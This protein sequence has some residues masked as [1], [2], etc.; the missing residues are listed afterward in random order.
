MGVVSEATKRMLVRTS[1]HRL[2]HGEGREAV[3][4]TR[5]YSHNADVDQEND[6]QL[7]LLPGERIKYK[8]R[9]TG[10]KAAQQ[11]LQHCQAPSELL[12]KLN[13]QVI[14]LKNLDMYAGLANGTRGVVVGFRPNPAA[15]VQESKPASKGKGGGKMNAPAPPASLPVVRFALA[16]GTF[17][18]KCVGQEEWKIEEGQ[19]TVATRRQLPLKLAWALSIHKSQGMTIGLLE[20]DVG[21]CFDAG[22][23]YVA[24]SRAVSLANLRVLNF[25]PRRVKA[26]QRVID[27]N[28]RLEVMHA[29]E[30][31]QKK[32]GRM[33]RLMMKRMKSC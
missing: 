22:Q 6:Q 16:N 20:A 2:G 4:P 27:F 26:S 3:Q 28:S 12:L 10:T 19:K 21:K 17:R 8:A 15:A 30:H 13:A 32:G 18:E 24:L 5:L 25:D 31:G 23:C 7:R 14:L 9:D 11:I 1:R 33:R 29:Q